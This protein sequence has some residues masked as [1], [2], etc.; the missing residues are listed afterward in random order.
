MDNRCQ[1]FPE[2][3]YGLAGYEHYM[4]PHLQLFSL[5]LTLLVPKTVHYT[6]LYSTRAH[7]LLA[8]RR[9]SYSKLAIKKF[10]GGSASIPNNGIRE[11]FCQIFVGGFGVSELV[12]GGL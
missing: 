11:A 8:I 1:S 12:A 2:I 10:K 7:T 6:R 3:A 5:A 9:F 4:N